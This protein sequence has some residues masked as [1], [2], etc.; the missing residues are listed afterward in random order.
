MPWAIG[1]AQAALD[2]ALAA[3]GGYLIYDRLHQMA[4]TPAQPGADGGAAR[5][6]V[7][8][9]PEAAADTSKTYPDL[10]D[11][12]AK[13]HILAGDKTGGGHRYGTGKPGKSEFPESWSDEKLLGEISDVATDPAADRRVRPNGRTIVE[14][15]RDGLRIRVVIENPRVGE[16]SVTAYST[17]LP[18]NPR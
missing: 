8:A 12:Q 15:T 13:R 16:R 18:R 10:T 7:P 4:P 1:A 9:A 5:E 11:E 14:G 3:V 2:A 6:Q 17:N